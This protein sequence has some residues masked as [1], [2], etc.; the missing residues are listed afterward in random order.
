MADWKDQLKGFAQKQGMEISSDTK[1]ESKSRKGGKMKRH[2]DNVSPTRKEAN[3]PYNFVP[4]N[5]KVVEG[6]PFLEN[7]RYDENRLTGYIDCDL[8][9][10]TPVYIRG[11]LNEAEVR[12]GKEA[13]DKSDFFS[14][15][16]GFRIPGSS[17]RGMIRT[18]VE[19]VSWSKF[20][21]FEDRG[22]YY[23]GLADRSSLQQ[24][25]QDRMVDRDDYCYPQIEAGF[26]K[27]DGHH[28]KIVPSKKDK[29]GCQIYRPLFDKYTKIVN[30]LG[31]R[32][33]KFTFEEV[34]FKQ[35]KP[36]PWLHGRRE[37]K[38]AKVT[39]VSTTIKPGSHPTKGFLVSSGLFGNKK[40]MHWLINEPDISAT[41]ITIP[42]CDI[43]NYK[44]DADRKDEANLLEMPKKYPEGIPCF[45]IPWEDKQN[46][47]RISFGH[48]GMF[49]LAYEK[50]IGEHVLQ[51]KT[52]TDIAE[53][54]FGKAAEKE[55][56]SFA[57]RVFFEDAV[58]LNPKEDPRM[59]ETI[60]QILSTP[61]PTTFQHYLVQ[62]SDNITR[63]NHYNSETIIRGNKLYWH[64]SGEEKKWEETKIAFP[65]NK[66]D[67][68]LHDNGIVD[69]NFGNS[70]A[71]IE[72]GQKAEI[73]LSKL[74]EKLYPIIL[75]AIGKYE[76]QHTKIQPVKPETKFK[77][78]IRFEN[79][80]EEELG[81]LLFTLSLP[82]GCAHK[83]GMGKPLGLGS[84]QITPTLVLS[85]RK[86]RYKSLFDD[87][88]NWSLPPKKDGKTIQG[89]IDDFEDDVLGQIGK[90][91]KEGAKLLWD[92]YRLRQLK[93]MLDVEEGKQLEKAGKIRYMQIDL[94]QPGDRRPIN[95]FRDRKVLPIPEK[96]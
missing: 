28:Y 81:A 7:D 9:T 14:P 65:I 72:H 68:I 64:K 18:L 48:T 15:N 53:A 12:E 3:A 39:S 13:R 83:I 19:I 92:T 62:D 20:G 71:F 35:V 89:Y 75:N 23:R 8:K 80:S 29:N 40:H 38:Y 63:L 87:N 25:Y 27:K 44:K 43:E 69:S 45:F 78:R 86:D 6:T 5:E 21:F 85:D 50:S 59:E 52:K 24:E 2:L 16:G 74:P 88:S 96:V 94:P 47:N 4:L 49:R 56:D 30:G 82:E 26:L 55:N 66:F 11:C 46:R 1:E 79:L 36:M 73:N 91:E 58:L 61:K 10:L 33:N 70:L 57:G 95:E 34:Y 37:L 42:E 54:I 77:S 76:T 17:L 67:N 84:V 93:T 41:K 90:E 22:L 32:L 60:P 51:D 31:R